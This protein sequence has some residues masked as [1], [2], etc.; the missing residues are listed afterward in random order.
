[1]RT[2]SPCPAPRRRQGRP[3]SARAKRPS[4]APAPPLRSSVGRT[5]TCR[6]RPPPRGRSARSP[7]SRPGSHRGC[8]ASC[9]HDGGRV[10]PSRRSEVLVRTWQQRSGRKSSAS[11]EMH[12]SGSS[13]PRPR[14]D[15]ARERHRVRHLLLQSPGKQTD[16]SPASGR[17]RPPSSSARSPAPLAFPAT[18]RSPAPRDSRHPRQLGQNQPPPPRSRRQPPA[19]R[20]DPSRRGH[21]RSM[22]P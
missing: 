17:S 21:A 8:E 20:G 11:R 6:L 12:L 2:C 3:L 13:P 10:R 5:G 7:T 15:Y 22:R 4:T 14:N 16:R 9:P 1:L 19:Q 18:P